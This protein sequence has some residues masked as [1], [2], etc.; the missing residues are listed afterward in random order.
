[1]RRVKAIGMLSGGLDSILANALI[2]KQGIEVKAVTFDTGLCFAD[3]QLRWGQK[4]KKVGQPVHPSLEI[5]RI[6][7][8]GPQYWEV[9]AHPR[10]GYG[11]NA[12][13]CVDCRIFMARQAKALMELHQ[14]DFVFTGEVLGQRPKSQKLPT[15]KLIEKESGLVGKLLR[16]LSALLLEP[17]W[18]EK[19]GLV[20]REQLLG[21]S[22]RSRKSQ[23]ALANQWNISGYPQPAGGGCLLADEGFGRRFHD[24]LKYRPVKN[25]HLEEMLLLAIGRHFRLS[26]R[27]KLIV[28]RNEVENELLEQGAGENHYRLAAEGL[29]GATALVEGEPAEEEIELA[30]R[31]VARYGKG[32]SSPTVAVTWLSGNTLVRRQEVVPFGE[33]DSFS[34]YLI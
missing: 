15:M 8:S 2:K 4:Q 29:M 3:I 19:E 1:M 20:D 25:V 21:I 32:K 9:I 31:I 14:A 17:T 13:P 28:G 7:I 22:G 5:E 34:E 30:S 26:E 16:P 27:V 6:D 10:F 23:I 24:L 33:Q 11:S 12:N 18:C